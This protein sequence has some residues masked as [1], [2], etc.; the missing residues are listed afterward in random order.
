MTN[1]LSEGVCFGGSATSEPEMVLSQ[2][3]NRNLLD[4]TNLSSTKWLHCSLGPP[5]SGGSIGI[6]IAPNGNRVFNLARGRFYVW[7]ADENNVPYSGF[8]CN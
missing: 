1:V 6:A 4:I 5:G 3:L 8:Y 7:S 2:N